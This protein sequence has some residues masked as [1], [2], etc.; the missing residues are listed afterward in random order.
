MT[1]YYN[2]PDLTK[3]VLTEDGWL[4]T[5]DIAKIDKDG[6]IYITGRIKS[7]IVL[8]G[9]K[10]VFPEDLE[11]IYEQSPKFAEVC[12]F[13]AKRKGGQKDGTEDI[14]V[15]HARNYTEI[16]GD[17]LYD[18]NRH[19]RVEVIKWNEDGTPNFGV[20]SPDVNTD[21]LKKIK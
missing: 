11:T 6:F 9:G 15:Y 3:E 10:K 20:P 1:G 14:L 12:V 18:P 17:P 7:M 4:H 2:R 8:S 16:V 19:T 5:G 13:G 21:E